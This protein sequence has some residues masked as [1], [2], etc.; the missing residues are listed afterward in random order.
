MKPRLA[1]PKPNERSNMACIII[2]DEYG[3]IVSDTSGDE[4]GRLDGV[5]ITSE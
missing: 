2:A 3:N 4:S 1:K 5:V